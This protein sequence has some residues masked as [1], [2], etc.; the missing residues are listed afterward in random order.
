MFWGRKNNHLETGIGLTYQ[1]GMTGSGE[2][3]SKNIL[4]VASI[5]Y[6]Y[7]K[8]NGGFFWKFGL[9]PFFAIADFGEIK[10]IPVVPLGGIAL[11]YT[12]K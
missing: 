7:Q 8:E 4:A 9:T 11:G 1:Q 5:R 10:S 6:R 3:Y 12:I 2:K